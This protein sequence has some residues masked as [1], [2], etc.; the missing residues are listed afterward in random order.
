VLVS[1]SDRYDFRP[2]RM[3][4]TQQ[5][6]SDEARRTGNSNTMAQQSHDHS[7]DHTSP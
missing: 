7:H 4:A 5:M 3:K 6:H 1:R 2:N